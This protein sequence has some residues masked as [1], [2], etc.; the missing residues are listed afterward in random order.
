MCGLI[1]IFALNWEGT[2]YIIYGTDAR[3]EFCSIIGSTPLYSIDLNGVWKLFVV[4]S[5]RIFCVELET[6]PSF[7]IIDIKIM[8]SKHTDSWPVNGV[9]LV[10]SSIEI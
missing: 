9:F 5:T 7:C 8:S 4:W 10:R 2:T 6:F 3:P 1:N